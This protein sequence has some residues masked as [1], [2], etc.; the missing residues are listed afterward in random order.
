MVRR[1]VIIQQLGPVWRNWQTRRIQNPLRLIP[2]CGFDSHLRHSQTTLSANPFARPFRRE[3][4]NRPAC[5]LNWKRATCGRCSRGF[6]PWRLRYAGITQIA[7]QRGMELGMVG[8]YVDRFPK[9]LAEQFRPDTAIVIDGN[10][11]LTQ[12]DF[13]D[14]RRAAQNVRRGLCRGVLRYQCSLQ[15]SLPTETPAS[16]AISRIVTISFLFRSG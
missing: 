14:R 11:E 4:Q 12:V 15:V 13:I 6:R 8:I 3:S 16:R 5:G 1:I 9:L 2:S 10:D 7:Q